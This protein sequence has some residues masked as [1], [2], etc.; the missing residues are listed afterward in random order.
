MHRLP[1]KTAGVSQ[2]ERSEN[3]NVNDKLNFPAQTVVS[4]Q[5]LW[6]MNTVE[7]YQK[8]LISICRH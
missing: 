6:E 2:L 8:Y 1:S 4:T 7:R 3:S 5:T